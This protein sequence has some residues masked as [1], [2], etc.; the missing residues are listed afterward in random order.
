MGKRTPLRPSYA[1]NLGT[2][3]AA[4]IPVRAICQSCSKYR[5]VDLVGLARVK[6]SDYDLWGRRTRCRIT[7]G[8]DGWNRFYFYGRGRYEIM[9]DG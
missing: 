6:G 7:A 1:A 2:L 5:D 9:R 8:C 4:D 3:I